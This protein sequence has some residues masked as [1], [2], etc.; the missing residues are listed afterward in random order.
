[1]QPVIPCPK[2]VWYFWCQETC[3]LMMVVFLCLWVLINKYF[4]NKFMSSKG[5]SNLSKIIYR[6]NMIPRFFIWLQKCPSFLNITTLNSKSISIVISNSIVN[7]KR[8]I[9][10]ICSLASLSVALHFILSPKSG[11]LK[12]SLQ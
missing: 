4:Q 5:L 1:M 6:E 7:G 3:V 9:C 8:V 12:H 10:W 11:S 2:L